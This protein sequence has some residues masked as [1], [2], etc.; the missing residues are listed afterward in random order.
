[1]HKPSKDSLPGSS[2][3]PFGHPLLGQSEVHKALDLGQLGSLPYVSHWLPI[4][5]P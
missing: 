3:T 4:E 2:W 5:M 1:M